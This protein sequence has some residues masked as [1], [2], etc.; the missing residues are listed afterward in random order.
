MLQTLVDEKRVKKIFVEEG[1][2]LVRAILLN[3]PHAGTE[4]LHPDPK[5]Q[6][7]IRIIQQR[8]ADSITLK[9]KLMSDF[10]DIH[11]DPLISRESE[12][13]SSNQERYSRVLE[14]RMKPL[15]P[16]TIW[17]L[18]QKL[19]E[20]RAIMECSLVE[21]INDGF[22]DP[23]LVVCS[24]IHLSPSKEEIMSKKSGRVPELLEEKGYDVEVLFLEPEEHQT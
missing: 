10:A 9:E 1:S 23:S 16:A 19:N 6:R 15:S 24:R 7:I 3:F 20:A 13:G 18:T 22:V 14:E 21:Q 5:A 8:I 2:V 11:Q 4:V 17:D 12:E